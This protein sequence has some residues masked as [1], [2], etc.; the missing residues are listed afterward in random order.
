M[1]AIHFSP[2]MLFA[3]FASLSL[4]PYNF[5]SW[6]SCLLHFFPLAQFAERAPSA[7]QTSLFSPWGRGGVSGR[8]EGGG[9]GGGALIS[10][11]KVPRKRKEKK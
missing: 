8:G 1:S 6:E 7:H 10:L 9:K 5:S 11:A 4:P 2:L 3:Y